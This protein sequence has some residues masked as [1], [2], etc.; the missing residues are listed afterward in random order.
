MIKLKRFSLSDFKKVM[1]I[2]TASFPKRQIFPI[3]SFQKYYKKYPEG[4]IVAECQNKIVGYAI[5]QPKNESAE[6]ISLAV[7]PDFRQKGIG[8]KLSG[9]LINHF[10]EKNIKEI[11]LRVRTEN[12]SAISFYQDLGFKSVKIIK[13]YYCN[14]DDALLMRKEI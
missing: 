6:F 5:G 12:K 4:F 11:T 1:E 13:N 8:T 2:E 7:Q 9:F 10:R 3:S 14:S